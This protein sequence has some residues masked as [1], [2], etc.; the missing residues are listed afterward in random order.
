MEN[1]LRRYLVR[2]PIKIDFKPNTSSNKAT[3]GIDPPLRTGMGFLP[4]DMLHRFVAARYAGK[5]VG[6]TTPSPPCIGVTFTLTL[7]GAIDLK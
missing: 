5:S 2:N 4:K 7:S 1:V 3:I 6:T